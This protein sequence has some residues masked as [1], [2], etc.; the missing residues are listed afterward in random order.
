MPIR[1]YKCKRGR[2]SLSHFSTAVN[3]VIS[4]KNQLTRYPSAKYL[5]SWVH[6]TQNPES[7]TAQCVWQSVR[8]FQT[9]SFPTLVWFSP[10]QMVEAFELQERQGNT[11]GP[12]SKRSIGV[13]TIVRYFSG[14]IE[15]VCETFWKQICHWGL[16][17]SLWWPCSQRHERQSITLLNL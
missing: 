7:V 9:K 15:K 3:L 4:P 2:L 13:S 11:S 6:L 1:L 16:F 17:L 10:K 5:H 8:I 14:M 12:R